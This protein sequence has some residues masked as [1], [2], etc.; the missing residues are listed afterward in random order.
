MTF[1][2]VKPKHITFY[3]G[4]QH[5]DF[6]TKINKEL[7]LLEKHGI[8]YTI[9]SRSNRMLPRLCVDGYCV[10]GMSLIKDELNNI[11]STS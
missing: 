4:T 6:K 11:L 2:T 3:L 9:F 7:R 8:D 10:A 1:Q 5:L